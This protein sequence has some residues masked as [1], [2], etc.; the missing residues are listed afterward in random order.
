MGIIG[1]WIGRIYMKAQL[2]EVKQEM[3]NVKVPVL[4]HL[5]AAMAGLTSIWAYG[6][7]DAMVRES[8]ARIDE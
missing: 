3:S 6:A 4:G 2:S 1:A 8:L 5:G 7:E